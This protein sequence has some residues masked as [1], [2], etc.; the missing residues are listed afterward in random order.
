MHENLIRTASRGRIPAVGLLLL[1][2]ACENPPPEAP[3]GI[4]VEAPALRPSDGLLDAPLLKR[5]VDLGIERDGPAL[6]EYLAHPDP[7]VRARAAFQMAS[8]A[9]ADAVP[10]LTGLLDDDAPAVRRDA[11]FALGQM[12]LPDGGS[13]L[14]DA[15]VRE[16]DPAVRAALMEAV[17]RAGDA[18]AM[19]RLLDVDPADEEAPWTRAVARAALRNVHP[20]GLMEAM[21]DRLGHPDPSVRELAA[22]A[23]GRGA[24]PQSWFDLADRVRE[25]LDGYPPD[26]PA[27]MHLV[28]ALGRQGHRMDLERLLHW[29]DRGEDWRIR[30]AV[31]RGFGATLWLD[32]PAVRT[33]L[34]RALEDE[35]PHVGVQAARSLLQG[36]WVPPDVHRAAEAWIG[37]PTRPWQTQ[38]PLLR[39]LAFHH[40]PEPVLDWTRRMRRTSPVA[41]ARGMAALRGVPGQEIDAFA[42][43]LTEDPDPVLRAAGVA[44]MTDRWVARAMDREGMERMH[45]LF[46]RELMDGPTAAALH[47][48]EPLASP[49]FFGLGAPE[50]LEEAWEHRR[51]RGADPLLLA[52]ILDALALVGTP[53]GMEV[54][55]AAL[56]DEDS[57]VR[58]AAARA[59]E[60]HEGVTIDPESL[61]APGPERTVDWDRLAVLGPAPRLRLETD[62]GELVV[63][64]APEEAPLTVQT[65]AE[66][67]EAG[68]HDGTRFHRVEPNFVIQAGD[69]SLGDGRGGPGYRIRTELTHIPFRR[70]VIGMA[71]SGK[72][73]EGSQYYLLHSTQ[74]HLDGG[75]TAF[76]WVESG[77]AVL[78]GILEGDRVLRM[79]V[80]ATSPG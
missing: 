12:S 78:D 33:V 44:A 22:L 49:A 41:V 3:S 67:A 13:S 24:D 65:L 45:D 4:P 23:F 55:E 30:A 58:R 8:V 64:L 70:G 27:A 79:T 34:I 20:D 40:D 51:A 28:L 14:L 5:L 60:A 54:V 77:W 25:A 6:G 19:A 10:E 36:L 37:D 31:A 17:G 48:L 26:E 56:E 11:A 61:A 46:V 29:L 57:R 76:G 35:S 50:A 15:L 80:E 39:E 47:A 52:G 75:Y 43:E 42:L 2:T 59:L 66:Q 7:D 32:I 18:E 68:L 69:V 72:D 16:E 71:S 38:A 1:A 73:T 63:R 9:H 74:L 21:A 62:R 53:A